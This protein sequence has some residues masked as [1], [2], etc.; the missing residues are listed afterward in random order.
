MFL[1]VTKVFPRVTNQLFKVYQENQ[2]FQGPESVH[3]MSSTGQEYVQAMVRYRS[4]LGAGHSQVQAKV[5]HRP[6]LGTG[7]G[8][9]HLKNRFRPCF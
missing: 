1:R 5:R 3:P 4:W 9:V 2:V 6:N 7:Q 8:K